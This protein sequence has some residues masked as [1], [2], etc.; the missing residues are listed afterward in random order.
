MQQHSLA[1]ICALVH[2]ICNILIYPSFVILLP[3]D[4]HKCGRNMY[5]A[6]D[7]YNIMYDTFKSL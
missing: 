7:V 5:D 4:G 3:E 2:N 6:Y 1:I